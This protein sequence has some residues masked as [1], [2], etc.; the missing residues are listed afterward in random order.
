M[1]RN[2]LLVA[3]MAT[4]GTAGAWTTCTIW[5]RPITS[6]SR[7]VASSPRGRPPPEGGRPGGLAL[8]CRPRQLNRG[9]N[10]RAARTFESIVRALPEVDVRGR[11]AVLAGVLAVSHRRAR[12]AAPGGQSARPAA[13][14]VRTRGDARRRRR[15][16]RAGQRRAGAFRR[17]ECGAAGSGAGSDHRR[18]TLCRRRRRRAHRSAQRA[19]ADEHRERDADPQGG[20]RSRRTSARPACARRR[21]SC[22]RRSGRTR[23]RTSCS[24][25]CGTTRAAR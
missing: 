20:A 6:P 24:T 12:R 19:D 10:R 5:C 1:L 3:T 7:Q 16:A 23:P 14:G 8:P 15:A 2:I 4:T 22:C 25:S 17:S 11:R 9:D 13:Q 21:C 18:P